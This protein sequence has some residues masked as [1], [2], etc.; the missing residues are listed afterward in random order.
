MIEDLS[1]YSRAVRSD[2]VLQPVDAAAAAA[3]ACANLQAAIEECTAAVVM[4]YLPTVTANRELLIL[5]FQN[6]IGNALKFR[7]AD[8][9]VRVD[10]RARRKV[11]D[12]LFWVRDNGIGIEPRHLTRIFGLGQRLHSTTQYPGTG[13]GLAICEKIVVRHGGRIWVESEPDQ[14]STFYFTVPVSSARGH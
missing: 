13:F 3:E 6:L 10:V 1:V 9:P 2:Q 14:G 11:D 8:R 4:D 7:A 5:L 12:W